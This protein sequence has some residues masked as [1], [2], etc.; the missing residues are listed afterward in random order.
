[1]SASEARTIKQTYAGLS[2]PERCCTPPPKHTEDS[3]TASERFVAKLPERVMRNGQVCLGLRVPSAAQSQHV[4]ANLS[5][6]GQVRAAVAQ[7]LCRL[8][9][10]N[11]I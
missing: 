8:C 3:H 10:C 5:A 1:M 2:L 6:A 7:R 9:P 11:S 4:F